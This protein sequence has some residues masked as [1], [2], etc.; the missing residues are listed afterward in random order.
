MLTQLKTVKEEANEDSP[1]N[2]EN[3]NEA[4]TFDQLLFPEMDNQF[5][6]EAKTDRDDALDGFDI[7]D[8]QEILDKLSLM[9]HD[10][11]TELLK[12]KYKID[13]MRV[14]LI[15]AQS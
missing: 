5:N 7:N 13:K 10:T 3:D 8:H 12:T 15:D 9:D 1:A 11:Y 6:E 4:D 14:D 2:T